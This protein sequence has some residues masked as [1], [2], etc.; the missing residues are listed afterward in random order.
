MTA[1][2]KAQVMHNRGLQGIRAMCF[3]ASIDPMW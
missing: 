2:R 1:C 3:Y